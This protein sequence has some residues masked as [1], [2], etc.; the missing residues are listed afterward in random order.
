MNRWKHFLLIWL[1]IISGYNA[2]AL[3]LSVVTSTYLS[4]FTA[5]QII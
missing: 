4:V 5:D 3:A 1:I 2:T